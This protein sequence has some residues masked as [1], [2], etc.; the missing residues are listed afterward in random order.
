MMHALHPCRGVHLSEE[1][2]CLR[3]STYLSNLSIHR[4]FLPKANKK[5]ALSIQRRGSKRQIFKA[6]RGKERRKEEG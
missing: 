4:H 5:V 3:I 6:E 2:G 1:R